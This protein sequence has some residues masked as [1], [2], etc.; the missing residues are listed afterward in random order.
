MRV[1]PARAV[2]GPAG[3]VLA[4]A[5]LVAAGAPRVA[6]ADERP[7]DIIGLWDTGDGA[8]VEV[9]ER[10]GLYHG[11]FRHFYD[12]PPADGVDAKNP[13]PALRG[14]PLVGADFILNF[15]FDGKKWTDGRIYNPE[16]GKQYKADLEMQDGVL[17]VRGWLGVRLLGRTVSWSRLDASAEGATER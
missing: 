11:K 2:V 13:D 8:H 9:Y 16:N 6:S 14:R 10:D 15:A 7:G 1:Q 12:E 17:K 3:L 5:M 4:L